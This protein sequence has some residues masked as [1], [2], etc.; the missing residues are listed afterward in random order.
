MHIS[1]W[2]VLLLK[3]G[4]ILGQTCHLSNKSW[5]H[6]IFFPDDYR[7]KVPETLGAFGFLVY[8]FL[9]AV[10]MDAKMPFRMGKKAGMIGFTTMFVPLFFGNF[11]FKWREGRGTTSLLTTE[12][13]L[14][15]FMKSVSAFT[16]ID[17]LLKDLKIKHSEFGRIALS[18]GMVTDMLA[19]FITFSN[20]IYWEGYH[21]MMKTICFCL[22]VAVMI[23]AVRP[24]M[25]WVI[26]QTPE[27]RPV[28]DVYIY[29]ILG[30]A[31]L[32][33]QLFN[34]I[35]NLFGPAGAF[36]LGLTIPNGYPLGATLVQKFES[37]NLG[38]ILPL[39]GS[40]TMM[41]VDF[42]WLLKEF[43]NLVR[44]EGQLYEVT[45]FILFVSATKFIASTIAAYAFK[46]PLR[47]SIALALILNNRGIFELAY[48]TYAVEIKVRTIYQ[49]YIL[50][51][52]L[53][54]FLFN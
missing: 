48:F 15:I 37:V 23:C 52:R 31:V 7:P 29:L 5:L 11:V 17:T 34:E 20:A 41:Q 28:K 42:I 32:S 25:F 46:M 40:L 8:W 2:N 24:A 1:K 53:Y 27:G 9:N 49:L 3:A 18:G 47:D 4:V 33:F 39:F 6:N 22:V 10:T 45:S 38:A 12:Y 50:I 44:M 43:G 19:F 30:L 14:L 54:G 21:G 26:R 35:I 13:R 36:V 16:S 51:R